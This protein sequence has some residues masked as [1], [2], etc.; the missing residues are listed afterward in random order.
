MFSDYPQGEEK[1]ALSMSHITSFPNHGSTMAYIS[2]IRYK[3]TL[4]PMNLPAI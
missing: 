4:M 2:L 1:A 3:C